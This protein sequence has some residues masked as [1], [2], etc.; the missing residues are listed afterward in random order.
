VNERLLLQKGGVLTPR[1]RLA[2]RLERLRRGK[3][4]GLDRMD[5][6]S[7]VSLVLRLATLP[8]V[9]VADSVSWPLLRRTLGR[10]SWWVVALSFHGPDAQFARVAEAQT[11]DD[12]ARKRPAMER[13][14]TQ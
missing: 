1:S 14:R 7:L 5:E 11:L 10:G 2:Y 4:A 12:A 9:T 8:F 6:V 3:T 13:E